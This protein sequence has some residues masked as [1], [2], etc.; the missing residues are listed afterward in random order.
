MVFSTLIVKTHIKTSSEISYNFLSP[1]C[2]T[3][4]TDRVR[5][6]E[7]NRVTGA[8]QIEREREREREREGGRERQHV[9]VYTCTYSHVC[10]CA[11]TIPFFGVVI[12]K[13]HLSTL[14]C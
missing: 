5:E 3:A 10:L 4:E 13:S 6:T 11:G 14:R 1:T 12:V 9:S 2:K 7:H 8:E